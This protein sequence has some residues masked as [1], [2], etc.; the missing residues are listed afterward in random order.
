ME[1][2]P[3]AILAADMVRYSRLMGEDEA[4]T[5]ARLKPYREIIDSLISTRITA[6]CLVAQEIA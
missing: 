3:T 2:R 6:V 4:G 1:W 5:L